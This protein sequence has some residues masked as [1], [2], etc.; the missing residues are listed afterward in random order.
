[1]RPGSNAASSPAFRPILFRFLIAS[2]IIL[3]YRMRCMPRQR[4]SPPL[5]RSRWRRNWSSTIGRRTCP[6]PCWTRSPREYGVKV[7]YLVYESQEEAIANMQAG[8]TYDVVVMESR[9][10][11]LLVEER[12]AWPSSIHK[13]S[14]T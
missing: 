12:S 8:E 14:P 7:K 11:P 3:A 5:H 4:P 13:I 6:S 1:M 9:Y 10:I 2:L